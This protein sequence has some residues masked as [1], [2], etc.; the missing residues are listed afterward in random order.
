MILST[1]SSFIVVL[2]LVSARVAPD[3]ARSNSADILPEI[4]G[5]EQFAGAADLNHSL[6]LRLPF[7]ER[8]EYLLVRCIDQW[9]EHLAPVA[10]DGHRRRRAEAVLAA[11]A[12]IF[13]TPFGRKFQYAIGIV[14]TTSLRF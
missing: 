14:R 4:N 1:S 5:H 3:D 8:M 10:G 9:L 6:F 13:Q 2:Q 12:N 11:F 7:Q